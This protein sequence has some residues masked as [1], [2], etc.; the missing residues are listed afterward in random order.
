MSRHRNVIAEWGAEER[1][2]E[3]A[4]SRSFPDLLE[5]LHREQYTGPV[6]LHFAQGR[7]NHVEIPAKP[8]TIVLDKRDRSTQT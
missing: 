2:R 6:I 5:R 3:L 7:P 8:E 1:L 4:A